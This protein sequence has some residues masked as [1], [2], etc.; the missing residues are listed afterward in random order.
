MKHRLK[1]N[2]AAEQAYT[3]DLERRGPLAK[4]ERGEARILSLS[5][6]P[7]PLKRFLERERSIIRVPLTP[8]AR[9]QL[10]Q[11]SRA[12]GKSVPELARRWLEQRLAREA[13]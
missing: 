10:E 7:A 12:T 1:K 4:V 6:Y 8:S 5:E 11:L 9:R 3:R 13:G 2:T